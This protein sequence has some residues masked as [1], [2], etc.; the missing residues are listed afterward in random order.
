[1][2]AE[3]QF[4]GTARV[5]AA[6][7]L[8]ELWR[9]GALLGDSLSAALMV[10]AP[11]RANDDSAF[12]RQ[13]AYTSVRRGATI[14]AILSRVAKYQPERV[15]PLLRAILHVATTQ[16]VFLDF[17][18]DFA[19][20]DEAVN[21]AKR[22]AG[23]KSGG[24]V[25]AI[26]RN[27][28]RA[29][30]EKRT[31]WDANNVNLVRVSFHEACSFDVRIFD[32]ESNSAAAPSGCGAAVWKLL[33]DCFEEGVA[34]QI[35]WAST[36]EPP[37]VLWP[38]EIVAE[39]NEVSP[40]F[41]QGAALREAGGAALFEEAYA[42]DVSARESAL[43]A[44]VTCGD[45]VLDFCAAPGG[46]SVVLRQCLQ[47][48]GL[49]VACDVDARRMAALC[50]TLGVEEC[51]NVDEGTFSGDFRDA[52]NARLGPPLGAGGSD[53]AAAGVRTDVVLIN[54][55]QPLPAEWLNAFA[56][57]FVDVPCSNSGVL[58]R[59]PEAR[60]RLDEKHFVSLHKLQREII[61][62]AHRCVRPGGRL[63]YSTCSILRRENEAFVREFL[64]V[65]PSFS[66]A[67]ERLTLPQWGPE[68]SDWRDGAYVARLVRKG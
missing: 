19:A 63:V 20:V 48:R 26:L 30:T 16:L 2:A 60:L 54:R 10:R 29:R 53:C 41:L 64:A 8:V 11:D 21:H 42:Q 14:D 25:N 43:F 24:M 28:L 68:S 45:R 17:V 3:S 52:H 6:N 37:L 27:L 7:A 9:R 22:A 18:P 58:A 61:E 35:A 50:R 39:S 46:K 47:G 57:V 34:R 31:V 51:T 38:R 33:T 66:L 62:R 13:L 55:D 15:S 67:E 44:M 65:S 12:A 40:R 5:M 49:L 56:V 1:M 36:A 59:R 32:E 23:A 4:L